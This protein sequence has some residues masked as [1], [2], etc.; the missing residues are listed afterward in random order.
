[1]FDKNRHIPW[2]IGD[3]LMTAGIALMLLIAGV[4]LFQPWLRTTEPMGWVVGVVLQSV[5]VIPAVW[6][7]LHLRYGLGWAALGFRRLRWRDV[8]VGSLGGVFLFIMAQG[9]GWSMAKIGLFA[10][11]SPRFSGLLTKWNPGICILLIL[12]LGLLGPLWEEM[13]FRGFLYNALL[14]RWGHG[15]AVLTSAFIFTMAHGEYS[16]ATLIIMVMG[17]FL[18]EIYRFTE[19]LPV[20]ILTHGMH[21]LLTLW[22]WLASYG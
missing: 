8:M 2:G 17:V 13:F 11:T 20:V 4:F 7:N 15:I 16:P 6:C 19:S 14:Q 22:I 18:T 10:P 21:N 5:A 1:M 12:A 9:I 3:V